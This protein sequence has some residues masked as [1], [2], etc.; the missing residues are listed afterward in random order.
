MWLAPFAPLVVAAA[1]AAD[2]GPAEPAPASPIATRQTYFSIPFRLEKPNPRAPEP[3]AVELY[4]STDFGATWQR[5]SRIEPS[6]GN[7]L[8]R[9]AADGEHW[10]II[11]TLDASGGA[12]PE[13]LERPGLQVL[14]DTTPPRLELEAARGE[15]GQ[16]VARWRAVDL[17]LKPDTLSIQYR[18]SATQSWQTV[19]LDR[20]ARGTGPVWTGEVSWWPPRDAGRIEI[21]AE[22]GDSASNTAVSQA[23]VG[24]DAAGGLPPKPVPTENPDLPVAR[25]PQ[26]EL[27]RPIRGPALES[28]RAEG[29]VAAGPNRVVFQSPDGTVAIQ[30]HPAV[31][32]QYAPSEETSPSATGTVPGLPAGE[33]LRVVNSTRF[34]LE[35]EVEVGPSGVAQVELW[36]TRD[37]GRTWKSLGLDDDRK[38]PFPV[39][40]REE[41]LYGF[42]VAVRSGAGLGGEPPQPG[43]KPQVWIGVDLAKPKARIR[44]T[45]H[46]T[47]EK[48]GHLLI[49][50]EAS[51]W[52]LRARPISILY[53]ET[54]DG[55][56]VPIATRLENVGEYAWLIDRRAPERVH[57]RLEVED[58][59]GN[60]G[61][62]ETPEPV[63][64]DQRP[65]QIHIRNVRSLG[66]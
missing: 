9:A 30:I 1:L 19:A 31:G 48:A 57:L 11:R 37:G 34:E 27:D 35:Y 41:G 17:N 36:A 21:R 44:S 39:S 8:F 6:K 64:L 3:T 53:G 58:E 46:L 25:R 14:I 55:P 45:E 40:V 56:W 42:R 32:S 16:I 51:D 60:L 10:F 5:H 22:V 29:P 38:S 7:F 49:R 54:R 4:V 65:P 15:M 59:A 47:G 43:A 52:L 2:P 61:I 66:E 50:W 33:R 63:I 20:Q 62:Y 24:N 12:R 23:Q 18:T 28:A 13:K 26:P